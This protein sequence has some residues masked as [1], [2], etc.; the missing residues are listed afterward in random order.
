MP[1]A[2]LCPVCDGNGF[3][4][5]ERLGGSIIEYNVSC[6]GCGGRGWIEVSGSDGAI[7]RVLPSRNKLVTKPDTGDQSGGGIKQKATQAKS[8]GLTLPGSSSHEK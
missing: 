7:P 5:R 6:H 4:D 2:T 1:K 3:T 8:S